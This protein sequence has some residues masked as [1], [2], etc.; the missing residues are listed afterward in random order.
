MTIVMLVIIIAVLVL[1][2]YAEFKDDLRDIYMKIR[3][4][5]K[6]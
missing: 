3:K 1:I 4:N 2:V 6:K 5:K